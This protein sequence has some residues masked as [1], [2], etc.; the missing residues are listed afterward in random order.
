M[1]VSSAASEEFPVQL[2]S[3]YMRQ[4]TGSLITSVAYGDQYLYSVT[5]LWQSQFIEQGEIFVCWELRC[6][7]PKGGGSECWTASLTSIWLSWL[8]YGASAGRVNV[9]EAL[10][11]YS[12]P[13]ESTK[14]KLS[15]H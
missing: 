14:G 12:W 5:L 9:S 3:F 4:R 7:L 6:R 8:Y 13:L 11:G 10:W 2:E 1:S 15:G